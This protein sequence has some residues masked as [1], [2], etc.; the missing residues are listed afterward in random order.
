V[1]L[2]PPLLTRPV[3][4]KP[5]SITG[6][7]RR[8][9]TSRLFD[10]PRATL[11]CSATLRTD[12]S[13]SGRDAAAKGGSGTTSRTL[14]CCS[15]ALESFLFVRRARFCTWIT[16][17][18]RF[19]NSSV[20]VNSVSG[21]ACLAMW[22][23]HHHRFANSAVRV[24]SVSNHACLAMQIT[25]SPFCKQCRACEQCVQPC[26]PCHVDHTI[27]V[28]RTVPCVCTVCPT[29]LALPCGSHTITVLQT[30]PCV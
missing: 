1:H 18:H 22:I 5:S 20:R 25:P 7:R 9:T 14:R 21:H 12:P 28:L 8:G 3:V 16:H 13:G 15:T 23:T 24:Y 17:H 19:A 2:Q 27:T 11:F 30:V 29:M 6:G 4:S 10:Q 26:L